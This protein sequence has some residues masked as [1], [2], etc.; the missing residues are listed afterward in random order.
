MIKHEG[1]K[2][3]IN[4]YL[5]S[6]VEL[7]QENLDA[8]KV[9]L[10]KAKWENKDTISKLTKKYE[11]ESDLFN[12][13][14]YSLRYLKALDIILDSMDSDEATEILEEILITNE[15]EYEEEEF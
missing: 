12:M 15:Q 1:L 2:H 5:E 14:W 7:Q 8:A 3:L 11:Y 9:E 6:F 10:D 13:T 4:H